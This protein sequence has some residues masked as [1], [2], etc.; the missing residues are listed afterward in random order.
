MPF[1]LKCACGQ[2]VSVPDE[3]R[4]RTGK[5]P[6]C[7]KPL[8]LEESSA[9]TETALA[10]PVGPPGPPSDLELRKR[11]REAQRLAS[12][13]KG[14][15][16]V[17][18][19]LSLASLPAYGL[20]LLTR[21][22]PV[23]ILLTVAALVLAIVSLAQRRKKLAGAITL[24]LALL[25]PPAGFVLSGVILGFRA[26]AMARRSAANYGPA[27]ATLRTL[28]DVESRHHADRGSFSGNLTGS[29]QGY[30]F[31]ALSSYDEQGG[32][33]PGKGFAY[34][35]VPEKYPATGFYTFLIN[36]RGTVYRRDTGGVPPEVWFKPEEGS[37]WTILPEKQ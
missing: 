37:L 5:C 13:G 34:Y 26:G 24:T 3:A 19:L 18:V 36:Q 20:L 17:S 10:S 7:G 31:G 28:A 35:A 30:R 27:V 32:K 25:V 4:G 21:F 23:P 14:M 16:W 15:G 9:E 12:A 33:D 29:S 6:K 1:K 11:K 2:K 8:L 22:F